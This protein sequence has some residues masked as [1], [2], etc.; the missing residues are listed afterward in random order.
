MT[1]AWCLSNKFK[2]T[3]TLHLHQLQSIERKRNS[4][5]EILQLF[6]QG[7]IQLQFHNL[8]PSSDFE[9]ENFIR[10]SGINVRRIFYGDFPGWNENLIG[11]DVSP[12][13]RRV[14]LLSFSTETRKRKLLTSQWDT[15]GDKRRFK[16]EEVEEIISK[17]KS[18]G[19][20][21]VTVGGQSQQEKY[22]NSLLEIAELMAEAEFHIGVDSGFMH[23][24]QLFLPPS[25]IHIYSKSGNFWSH[26][27]FR[28][29]KNGMKLNVHYKKISKLSFLFIR[30]RYNSPMIARFLHKFRIKIGLS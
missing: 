18:Q 24:A 7:H 1:I 22:R 30:I 27:L 13:L 19:Y 25:K 15:T 5:L 23:F 4:F 29:L 2:Q 21:V 20:E 6:P 17:Y 8:E 26:H 11:I 9:F 10:D 3:V 12:L 16:A 28:G 14:P